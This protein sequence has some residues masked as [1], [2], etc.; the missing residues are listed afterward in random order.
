MEYIFYFDESFHDRVITLNETGVLN[1]MLPNALDSYI[2]VFWGCTKSK[3]DEIISRLNIFEKKYIQRFGLIEGK[4]L[5][6]QIIGKKN[7]NHG[8][9]S[10]NKDAFDF[11]C[12][13]FTMI[14]QIDPILQIEIISKMELII[15]KIV[16]N[17]IFDRRYCI[18]KAI[19]SYSL[20]KFF[21]VYHTNELLESLFGIHDSKTSY[22]FK[23]I[24]LKHIKIVLSEIK[25][26]KRKEREYLALNQLY[27]IIN[28][29]KIVCTNE[30]E[31]SFSYI[32]NFSGLSFL[33]EELNIQNNSV[34]LVIDK[35]EKTFQTAQKFGFRSVEQV[36]SVTNIQV[37]LSDWIGGFIGRMI[38]AL[39]NDKNMLEDSISHIE[40]IS[41]ND[42][43]TKRIL[44]KEWF[45]IRERE[46]SLYLLIFNSLIIGHENYWTTMTTYNCDQAVIFYALLR[47]FAS[48]ESYEKF[49]SIEPSLHSEYFNTACLSELEMHYNKMENRF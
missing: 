36:D 11:Y 10:F 6:S 25:G 5:K 44:S 37:R 15:R 17:M 26:I 47:Y 39:E 18:N 27:D 16:N 12:D 34:S 35:E 41:K 46:Y 28:K 29:A 30:I 20:T 24:L 42:L 2:G 31:F 8:V 43:S 7:Y 32:P 1:N 48:Y 33:L 40:D 19:F 45:E 14:K 9:R 38:Y 3:I 22:N 23:R 13:L 4:E 49:S 21:N